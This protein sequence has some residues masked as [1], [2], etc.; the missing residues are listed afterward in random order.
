MS[1]YKE[2]EA[3]IIAAQLKLDARINRITASVDRMNYRMAAKIDSMAVQQGADALKEQFKHGIQVTHYDWTC[4]YSFLPTRRCFT[5]GSLIFPC[6]KAYKGK[7][8]YGKTGRKNK[9]GF[10]LDVNIY[11]EEIWLTKGEFTMR[12]LK[13]QL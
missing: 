5:S 6:T 13:G 11:P 12:K 1:S 7:Q 2:I 8:N 9:N 10:F 4:E 3:K